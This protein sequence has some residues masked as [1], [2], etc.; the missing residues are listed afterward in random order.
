MIENQIDRIYSPIDN[1]FLLSAL[2]CKSL[3]KFQEK[4]T[5]IRCQSLLQITLFIDRKLGQPS[6]FKHIWFLQYI[7]RLLYDLTFRCQFQYGFLIRA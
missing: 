1:D 5:Q 6:K 7:F 3:T 2:E 4:L